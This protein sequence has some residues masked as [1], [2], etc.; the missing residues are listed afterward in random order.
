MRDPFRSRCSAGFDGEFAEVQRSGVR[1]IFCA[2]GLRVKLRHALFVQRVLEPFQ[3]RDCLLIEIE[4]VKKNRLVLREKLSIIFKHNEVVLDDFC[5]SGIGVFHVDGAIGQR[6]ITERVI[7]AATLRIVSPYRAL[8]GFQPSC[9]SRNS[10]VS[11]RRKSGWFL[12]IR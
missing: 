8:S 9:R 11:P 12:Q 2:F 5:I 3:R 4:P 7:D 1:V 6:R 10:W